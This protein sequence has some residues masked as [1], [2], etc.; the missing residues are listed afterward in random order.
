M[1][2]LDLPMDLIWG[3]D[4]PSSLSDFSD[5]RE[6]EI[7]IFPDSFANGMPYFLFLQITLIKQTNLLENYSFF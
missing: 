7:F 5:A 4:Q 3:S 2:T 1:D 6:E